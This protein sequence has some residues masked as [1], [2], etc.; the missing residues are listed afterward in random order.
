M[1]WSHRRAT[2]FEI[3]GAPVLLIGSL[4][5]TA[6]GLT[7]GWR[8]GFPDFQMFWDSAMALRQGGDPYLD[9]AALTHGP[10][11]NPPAFVVAF[12]PLTALP[13]SWAAW[14][15]TALSLITLA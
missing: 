7:A 2:R 1:N 11:M 8:G 4:T 10:N 15:W 13:A 12:L 9:P 14:V 6:Y 5:A 3:Y